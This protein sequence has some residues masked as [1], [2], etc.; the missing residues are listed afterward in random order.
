MLDHSD[1]QVAGFESQIRLLKK[2][3]AGKINTSHAWENLPFRKSNFKDWNLERVLLHVLAEQSNACSSFT[4]HYGNLA[5][6]SFGLWLAKYIFLWA[7]T[8][9]K[10]KLLQ[11]I[12]GGVLMVII[13]IFCP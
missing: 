12:N 4:H 2:I 11:K 9:M 5:V 8:H 6:A 1:D 3:S 13:L 10:I 7:E